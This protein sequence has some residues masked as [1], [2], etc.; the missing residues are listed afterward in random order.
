MKKIDMTHGPIGRKTIRFALLLALT[1][2]L[3]QVFNTIDTII[4]GQFVGKEAMA[5]VGSNTPIIGFIVTF[6]IGISIGANVVISQMTGKGNREG[7]HRAVFSTLAFALAAGIVMTCLSEAVAEPLLSLLQVPDAL[8]PLSAQYLRIFFLALPGILVYNFASA[9]FRSQGD[10]KT[11]LFCLAAAGVIK[12]II[13]YTLVAFFHQGVAAV[14]ISTTCAT[15]LSSAMLVTIL[16]R[17]K[18]VIHLECRASFFDLYILREI[19]RIGTPAGVQAAVFCLSN[20][21]IQSAINSLGADVMA[22]SA[23]AFNLDILCYIFVNAFGQACTT[24]VGQN[25]GAGDMARCRR[26]GVITTLQNL[27][28]CV[29]IG[30]PILYFSPSLLALFTS[31]VMVISYGVTRMGYII[32][33]EP[34]NL[35][36]EMI[37]AYLRGFGNS[38]SP[39]LITIVGICGFRILYMGAVFPAIPSFDCLMTVYPLSW[40]VTA[41]GLSVL[42]FKTRR[43]YILGVTGF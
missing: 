23:A 31:D 39:A 35:A 18:H 9:I 3:Q 6:F 25:Y 16:L 27:V 19:L 43:K 1:G 15:L 5:A 32:L 17:S 38:L 37:S 11:P 14:A 2:M 10:T 34:L 13:S 33:A 22:A 8:I 36:I 4:M 29:I 26:V 21:V 40:F 42:L 12:V 30:A 41:V 7:I 28:V 20:I 24:F